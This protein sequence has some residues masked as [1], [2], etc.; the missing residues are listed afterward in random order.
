MQVLRQPNIF[1][2]ENL[3]PKASLPPPARLSSP[4]LAA[5][6]GKRCL[7]CAQWLSAGCLAL[8]IS[9][10]PLHSRLWGHLVHTVTS[11]WDLE[12]SGLGV[13]PQLPPPAPSLS[14]KP[15]QE[16]KHEELNTRVNIHVVV[17]VWKALST[18][19]TW[20]NEQFYSLKQNNFDP[21][22]L[23]PGNSG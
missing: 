19:T 4:R 1:I 23:Q 16:E 22:S 2:L 21:H 3:L 10:F 13:C 9:S 7:L 5:S 17:G 20:V 15:G 6:P 14:I 11:T 8:L 18:G 12:S